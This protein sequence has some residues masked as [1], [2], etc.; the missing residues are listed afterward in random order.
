MVENWIRIIS[1][2]WNSDT[3]K[4]EK[5]II[6]KWI[7]ATARLEHVAVGGVFKKQINLWFLT[8]L[9]TTSTQHF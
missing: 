5:R 3:Q 9:V 4:N 2:M 7:P 8:K 1:E 6:F